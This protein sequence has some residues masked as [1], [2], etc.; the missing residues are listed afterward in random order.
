[1]IDLVE[2][3][4][5]SGLPPS[6]AELRELLLPVFDDFPDEPPP[7]SNVEMVL[8]EIERYL[9]SRP[10]IDPVPRA[11]RPSPDVA[12]A[13]ELLRGREIVLIGGQNRPNHK[14]ALIKAFNLSDVRWIV[15]PEHTSFTVFEPDV[16]R[17]EVA[18]VLLAIRWSSHDYDSVRTY[19]DQYGKPLVRLPGGYNANQVAHHI[20]SQAGDRLRA[21]QA[22]LG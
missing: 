7:S 8:R 17:P 11:H 21:A 16:A 15:T 19:C 5:A 12:A 6:N 9:D 10:E 2:E 3:L 13:A 1:M 22:P 14:A 18:V 20:M 4:V